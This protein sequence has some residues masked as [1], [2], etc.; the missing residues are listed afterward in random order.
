MKIL[1]VGL[2]SMGQRR[3]RLLKK[4]DS[5]VDIIGIDT[6]AERRQ[7]AADKYGIRLSS[8]LVDALKEKIDGAVICTSPT[9]HAAILK[10][11]IEHH[12]IAFTE[13]NLVR[14]D[15]ET[16][17]QHDQEVFLSS[18]L[19][20]R[21]DIQYVINKCQGQRVNY[22]YHVGQYL[23]D[24]HPWESYKDYFVN[25]KETNGCRELF[26][27][28]LPWIV[29][30]FGKVVDTSVVKDKI[31]SLDIE[32]NDNFLVLLQH[33][34]G[35][36]GL[37]A[38]DVAARKAVRR[39]EVYSEQIHLFWDGTPQS[40][41]DLDIQR[42]EF[43]SISLYASIERDRNYSENIIED[44]YQDELYAYLEVIKNSNRN[45]VKYSFEKDDYI[46]SLIDKLEGV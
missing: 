39:L 23:S 27:I 15:Y 32:Y 3:I 19:L 20:Y 43:N 40:L 17:K 28:E 18:T 37:L 35:T 30:A 8:S 9:T 22:I 31:T 26:A 25:N 21:K 12:V 34:N 10:E 38:V 29:E 1:V 11:L 45:L 13:L 4:L 44:A 33:S 46:L 7:Y 36:K 24:W 14:D 41:K 6:N 2:G 16:F 5:T 42:G